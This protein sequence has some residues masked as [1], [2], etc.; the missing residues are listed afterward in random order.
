MALCKDG[1]TM[2]G[3]RGKKIRILRRNAVTGWRCWEG[4]GGDV[5]DVRMRCAVSA[6]QRERADA[7]GGGLG[8]VYARVVCMSLYDTVVV[9][10]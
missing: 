2:R 10:S 3:K 1:D 8:G 6:T 7:M 5:A 4:G 9:L